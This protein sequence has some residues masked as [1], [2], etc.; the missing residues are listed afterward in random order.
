MPSAKWMI[1]RATIVTDILTNIIKGQCFTDNQDNI[2]DSIYKSNLV[3]SKEY[4]VTG[5]YVYNCN[6][7]LL[8]YKDVFVISLENS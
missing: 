1:A 5:V 3:Y 7:L 8:N 4:N 2:Q 6:K